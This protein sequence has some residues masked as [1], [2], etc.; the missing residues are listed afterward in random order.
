MRVFTIKAQS[1]ATKIERVE[2]TYPKRGDNKNEMIN[3]LESKLGM[4]IWALE[5]IKGN[6]YRIEYENK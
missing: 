6:K 2:I 4:R 5:K 3:F 1:K